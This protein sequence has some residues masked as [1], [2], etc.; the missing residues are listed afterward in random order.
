VNLFE[1]VLTRRSIRA[2]RDITPEKTLIDDIIDASRWTPSWGNTQPWN[3]TVVRGE[4]LNRFK[5]ESVRLAMSG[6]PAEP[7]VPMP[8][9]WPSRYLERYR[10]V[11]RRTLSSLSIARDDR[12]ERD[13]FYLRMT[14]LFGAPVLVVLSIEKE[15]S[16]EY[17]MLDAGAF[18]QTLCLLAHE[19]GVG[20]CI[21]AAAVRY[22][23]LMRELF[24]IPQNERIVAGVALGYSDGENPVNTF[25]RVRVENEEIVRWVD[26]DSDGP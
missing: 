11:G 7:D 4:K 24:S 20:S 22:P 12:K 16:L 9:K 6:A 13:A 26:D 5:K 19:K 23:G 15:L 21:M 18:I 8:E 14:E 10:D 3:V 25:E 1:A 2:F 17:A